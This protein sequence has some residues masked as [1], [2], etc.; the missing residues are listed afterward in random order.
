MHFRE[1]YHVFNPILRALLEKAVH[2]FISKDNDRL[3]K[4][5]LEEGV[6][7]LRAHRNQK[8]TPGTILT[9]NPAATAT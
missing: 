4:S 5:S 1:T 9:K 2:R 6:Q 7:A 8:A 3:I